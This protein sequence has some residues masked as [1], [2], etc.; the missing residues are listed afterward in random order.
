MCWL[1]LPFLAGEIVA[2]LVYHRYQDYTGRYLTAYILNIA[3][4]ALGIIAA[5]LLIVSWSPAT[6]R[7]RT[8]ILHPLS[9]IL[10]C[11]VGLSQVAQL[12]FWL[13]VERHYH[14]DHTAA[15]KVNLIIAILVGLAVTVYAVRLQARASG[16]ALVLGWTTLTAL[17]LLNLIAYANWSHLPQSSKTWGIITGALL[18][19]VAILT[20]TYMCRPSE[21]DLSRS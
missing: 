21:P 18:V 17:S 10:L 6:V 1:G 13:T 12:I 15:I 19:A 5:I 20:I 8:S 9:V 3:S 14:V 2:A 11:A 7:R 16:G 4:D